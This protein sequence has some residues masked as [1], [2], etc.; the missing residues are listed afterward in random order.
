[1]AGAPPRRSGHS[2]LPAEIFRAYDIRGIVGE[3]LRA[4][5]VEQIGRAIAAQGHARGADTAVVGRDARPSGAELGAALIKGLRTGGC[6]TVD[7]GVVPTPMLYFASEHL[8]TASAVMITGSHNPARY[9]GLKIMIARET[10]HSDG[11]AAIARRIVENRLNV[12]ASPGWLKHTSVTEAYLEALRNALGQTHRARKIVIDCGNGMGGAIAPELFAA[13][14]HEV[15]E[16]HCEVDGEF[17]NHHPDPSVPANLE[18]LIA[19][20][21]V[22]RADIGLAFDGDADRL[23][24]VDGNGTIIWPDRLMMLFAT[25]VLGTDPGAAIVFDVKCSGLLG[26]HIERLGGTPVMCR[27]GHSFIRAELLKR[28]APLG[29]EMTGHL[30][31]ADRWNGFDDALYASGRLMQILDED[32]RPSADIFAELPSATSTPE[33][34]VPVGEG[35]QH[36]LVER[37][38][39]VDHFAGA[40]RTTIDGLRVD[41]P[42][43]WGL[44]RGS[45][46]EPCLVVR[47][48][49]NDE[50]A[51]AR[52][53]SEFAR[54][55]L[56]IDP[57][58]KLDW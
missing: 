10:L 17:P 16:L 28:G 3:T 38:L 18:D 23:G 12:G 56:K 7:I 21:G 24:I 8:D 22:E 37:L 51:L 50:S 41:Y 45:N 6:N 11:I 49:G 19:A 1:M 35:E 31:F 15:V 27:T 57:A 4:P 52:I 58:L 9:N 44:A 14:G 2:D 39:K 55:L 20:V 42:D 30:F 36:A 13:M 5:I 32:G 40:R 34:R 47:F 54:A 26:A 48:E 25:D 46:T 29:G 53:K 33:I 43:R